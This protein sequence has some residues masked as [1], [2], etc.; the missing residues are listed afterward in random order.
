M[1]NLF[2]KDLKEGLSL[3]NEDFAV[4]SINA[5]KMKD[6]RT[7]YNVELTDNTGTISGKIWPDSI[8]KC[9]IESEGEVVSVDAGIEKYRDSLQIK[10]KL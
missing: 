3:F 8:A 2:V 10:I 7:Y 6:G 4:K 1:K 5:A 9:D